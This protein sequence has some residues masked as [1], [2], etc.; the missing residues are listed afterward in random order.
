MTHRSKHPGAL[1]FENWQLSL[2]APDSWYGEQEY[3]LYTDTNI[4][5]A[6]VA[7][8]YEVLVT[9]AFDGPAPRPSHALRTRDFLR[10][11]SGNSLITSEARFTGGGLHEEWAALL[12]LSLGIRVH[13]GGAY[14]RFEQGGDPRGYPD[15]WRDR[16]PPYLPTAHNSASSIIPSLTN[17]EVTF[18][19]EDLLTRFHEV[20]AAQSVALIKAARAYQAAAWYVQGEPQQAWLRLVSAVETAAVEWDPLNE[21]PTERLRVS[22]PEVVRLL[23]DAGGPELVEAV[24][25]HLVPTMGATNKF[26]KFLTHFCPAPPAVR[27]D[28]GQFDYSDRRAFKQAMLKIYEYRSRALHAGT[29]FPAPMCWPPLR[30]GNPDGFLEV[31][32]GL[33]ASTHLSTWARE[34][35]PILLHTFEHIVCGALLNWWRSLLPTD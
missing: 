17:R 13:A 4:T 27:P 26:L 7:G 25:G 29:P 9:G 24:A 10:E 14:R 31:S 33:S 18:T 2:S 1:L 28:F 19:E 12:S 11:T 6:L 22:R 23:L 16:Q 3:L 20:T 5:G 15:L 32:P 34:E 35:T 21:H 30:V 8:P